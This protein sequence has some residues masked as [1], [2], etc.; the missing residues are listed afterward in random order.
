M[1]KKGA[2]GVKGSGGKPVLARAR[3][4]KPGSNQGQPGPPGV[5]MGGGPGVGRRPETESDANFK[6]SR[7]RGQLQSGAIT[8]L[9]HFRGAGVKGAAPQDYVQA[10]TAAEQE[11]ASAVELERIPADAREMVKQYFSSLKQDA[12]AGAPA[13]PPGASATGA[14]DAGADAVLKE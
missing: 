12:G 13:P 10:L 6:A 3:G 5:G 9:S 2:K 8:A 7:V 4:A 14:L 11:A 1:G